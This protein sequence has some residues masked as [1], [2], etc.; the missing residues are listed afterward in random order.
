MQYPSVKYWSIRGIMVAISI[1]KILINSGHNGY[2]IYQYF[3]DQFWQWLHYSSV[4]Y[5]SILAKA[6]LFISILL[7]N[8]GHNGYIFHIFLYK[9][10]KKSAFSCILLFS[11]Q[12]HSKIFSSNWSNLIFFI[13]FTKNLHFLVFSYFHSNH[14]LKFF[15][16]IGVI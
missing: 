7:M 12:S 9:L 2:I 8:S 10:Y 5:W 15:P 11:L 6:T 3:T 13:Y 4:F 1:S 16:L 14:T